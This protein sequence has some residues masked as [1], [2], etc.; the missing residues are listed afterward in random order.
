MIDYFINHMWQA[1][2][3][4]SLLFLILEL[5]NGDFFIMC[6]AIGSVFAAVASVL[7]DSIIV[8]IIVFAVFTL[9]SLAFV[10]PVA[11]R[12]FHKGEDHRLSNA[13]ALIGRIGRVIEPIE[14]DGYGR[15]AIDGDDWKAVSADGQ[16]IEKGAKVCVKALDSI[17]ITVER[18][19]A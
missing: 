4:L 9:L 12:W 6:F 3:L 8:Q 7:T 11:L 19:D 2:L 5:T 1:W 10:R 16:P 13:D 15:V 17:I 14:A 18:Q